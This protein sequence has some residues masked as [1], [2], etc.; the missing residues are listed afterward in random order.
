MHNQLIQYWLWL[1]RIATGGTVLYRIFFWLIFIF[2]T[3][4]MLA[5][6][7]WGILI[8]NFFWQIPLLIIYGLSLA[9][10]RYFLFYPV[11]PADRYLIISLLIIQ[12][13]DVTVF[14][15]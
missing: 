5:D 13:V 12:T 3:S 8:L 9:G 10:L 14:F 6:S 11:K 4:D 2:D 1:L 7:L 15:L